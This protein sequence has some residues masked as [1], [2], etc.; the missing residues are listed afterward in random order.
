[1]RGTAER[2]RRAVTPAMP[3]IKSPSAVAARAGDEGLAETELVRYLDAS[4]AHVSVLVRGLETSGLV[5]DW[6]DADDR[7]QVRLAV[8][9]AGWELLDRLGSRQEA[10]LRDFVTGIDAEAMQGIA[11]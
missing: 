2:A 9:D 1:M 5:R 4:R 11:T 8:T 10:A 6:R 7:R 3:P